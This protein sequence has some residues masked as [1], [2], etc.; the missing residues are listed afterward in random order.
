VISWSGLLN[1]IGV[2]M[3]LA[4]SIH[5]QSPSSKVGLAST[6]SPCPS[7]SPST[8]VDSSAGSQQ[9]KE[10][11]KSFFLQ[12]PI[13]TRFDTKYA[14]FPVPH[15][16]HVSRSCLPA[17]ECWRPASCLTKCPETSFL[18]TYPHKFIGQHLAFPLLR[19][20][21][22]HPGACTAR[23]QRQPGDDIGLPPVHNGWPSI[24]LFIITF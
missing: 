21:G 23:P 11:R 24:P 15:F 4:L 7:F 18:P 19:P 14:S 16:S 13:L 22:P 1:G 5:R 12:V 20:R 2:L 6:A 9:R 17:A 3:T 8:S 10:S